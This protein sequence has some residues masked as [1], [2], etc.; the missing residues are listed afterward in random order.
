[1]KLAITLFAQIL[2]Q[3]RPSPRVRLSPRSVS[4]HPCAR[5]SRWLCHPAP[6]SPQDLAP[7]RIPRQYDYPQVNSGVVVGDEAPKGLTAAVKVGA[8]ALGLQ[9]TASCVKNVCGYQIAQVLP[10][11]VCVAELRRKP[12]GQ[13]I[14]RIHPLVCS[15]K[16]CR[17]GWLMAA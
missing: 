6:C 2:G 13:G 17:G 4:S 1:M 3:S 14:N 8:E 9:N 12:R 5:I 10:S 16:Q 15:V 7:S 11:W